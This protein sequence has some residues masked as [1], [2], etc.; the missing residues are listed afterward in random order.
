MVIADA[1]LAMRLE[2]AEAHANAAFVEARAHLS[3]EVGAKWTDV[4]GTW[5][6]YDGPDSPLTQTFGLGL[7]SAASESQLASLEAFFETRSAAV[8]HEVSLM[9]DPQLLSLLAARGYV[10][11]EWSAVLCQPLST[12]AQPTQS[13]D[14]A[15]RL[16][17]R[18]EAEQW[19]EIAA[20]GWGEQPDLAGFMRS[21]GHVTA[22]SEG[23]YCFVAEIG[24]KA[25]ASGSLHLH[26]GVALL[27]GAST[28]PAARN[29]GAQ[30][31]LL[32]AR[33]AYAQAQGC[34][35]AMMAAAPGSSSQRNAQR[36]GFSV[37][38]S[39]VKFTRR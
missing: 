35:L 19:A 17:G 39:R 15:V 9:A 31:A 29:R 20:K 27:S 24:G 8:A 25:V 10:V 34:D 12:D 26:G 13:P 6:M 21:L 1:P 4:D 30:R 7:F 36:A 32:Q 14:V 23:T 28:I 18:D 3:P 11:N 16:T 33:L 5:A 37:V 22:M 38:Y 2:R